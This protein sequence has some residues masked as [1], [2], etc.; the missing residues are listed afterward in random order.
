MRQEKSLPDPPKTLKSIR[1]GFDAITKHVGLILFPILLDLFIWFAPHLRVKQRIE[2]FLAGFSSLSTLENP[3]LNEVLQT[4]QE[5]W[6]IIAERLNLVAALRSYPVGI[7]S[8]LGS[9][10]PLKT[11][12]G[13]PLFVEIRSAGA[14]LLI[15]IGLLLIGM[16]LGTLYYTVVK[17]AALYDEVRL[18]EAVSQWPWLIVHTLILGLIWFVLFMAISF[19]GGCII[20]ASALINITIAQ[21][22]IFLLSVAYLWMLFPLFFSPHGIFVEKKNA[23]R[24]VYDSIRMTN[25]S[26][27]QT[28]FFIVLAMLI[29]QGLNIVW[30]VPPENSWLMLVG[31]AGHAFV[32]TA[33]L[34]A[35]FVYYQD[36]SRWIRELR[37][38][39]EAEIST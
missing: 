26:F 28:G 3:E 22:A 34:A 36:M 13:S 21:G 18:R 7:F 4:N 11:P 30:Q 14:A 15:V 37:A 33:V 39:S 35:S 17:Q 38:W 19:L 27:L 5:V 29:T 6:G 25:L 8:L 16:V 9:I 31:I 12:I 23:W 2:R 24:S 10:F 1:D 20:V 32:S